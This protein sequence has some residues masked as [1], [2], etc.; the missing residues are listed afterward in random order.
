MNATITIT[1]AVKVEE[2]ADTLLDS[3]G[4]VIEFASLM[5]SR[6]LN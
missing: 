3:T 1:T 5:N 4:S 6:P 2:L